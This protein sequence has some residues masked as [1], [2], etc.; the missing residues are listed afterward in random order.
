MNPAYATILRGLILG[1]SGAGRGEEAVRLAAGRAV[2]WM[3][4]LCGRISRWEAICVGAGNDNDVRR[5][6]RHFASG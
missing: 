6:P 4:D 3:V 1:R 5:S 2:V